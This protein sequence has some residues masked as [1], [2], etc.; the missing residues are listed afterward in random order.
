MNKRITIS[1]EEL[2]EWMI[3]KDGSLLWIKHKNKSYIGADTSIKHFKES[4]V[5]YKRIE[6]NSNRFFVHRLIFLYHNG[7]MPECIDHSDGDTLNNKISNLREATYAQNSANRK[8]RIGTTSK[9]KGVN[10]TKPSKNGRIWTALI[11]SN[12][13]LRY[14]GRFHTENAAALAYNR[15]AVRQHGEFARLN[16]INK[17]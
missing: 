9:Y 8:A 16:V 6:I 2:K 4:G 5:A 12:N 7:Y 13:K 17:G 3:E 11:R 14:I 10:K 1:Q 15:E